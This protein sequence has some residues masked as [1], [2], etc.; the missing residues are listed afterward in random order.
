MHQLPQTR[1]AAPPQADREYAGMKARTSFH[2]ALAL[3]A[4]ALTLLAGP[5]AAQD[6]PALTAADVSQPEG[7]DD[8]LRM[9]EAVD[10][11]ADPD[12]LEF[13]LEAS[14]TELEIVPGK[15]TPAWTY[16]GTL[17]GPLIR[18][19]VGDRLIV[20][21]TN[22]LPEATTIHWHGVRVPNDMD[23]AP[24]LTQNPVEPGESFT[25]EFTLRDAGTYWYHP[26]FNS[27]AQV[28]RGLYGAIVVE[29][30]N[31]PDFGDELVIML[32]DMGLDDN[33]QFLPADRG[34]TFGV[35]FGREGDT[36]LLNGKLAPTLKVRTGK[37]QRWRVINAAITRYFPLAV[38]GHEWTRIGGDN[39]LAARS[40][41]LPR[42]VLIPGERADLIFTPEG[43][44][45][46]EVSMAWLPVDRGWG[47]AVGT[48]RVPF[49]NVQTVD[50]AAVQP[51]PVP[52]DLRTIAPVDISNAVEQTVE[53]SIMGG[54][55]STAMMGIN[56]E[57][58]N[59]MLE[60]EIGQTQ[61][62]TLVNNSDFDHPFHLHGFF[63]QVLDDSRVP[64]WKDTV[65]VPDHT[66]LRIAIDFDERRG[67][68]MF[69]CH[70]L[71]HAEAG[72]MASLLVR[73][74]N[75]PPG[76]AS[77]PAHMS[78]AEH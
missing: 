6:A 11:N 34:G 14:V 3:A 28:S 1:A 59:H 20:H 52:Q 16:N 31:E 60:A 53:L 62:W 51:L 8:D 49:L 65:N 21:F 70:I 27:P 12:V 19:K 56:G 5:A 26:H 77:A 45:G 55:D 17:P 46:D 43:E 2:G 39:G 63:F 36:I 57:A 54:D 40:E 9:E 24:R 37:Q 66:T 4:C 47:T 10:A 33:G 68:W 78:H 29:D 22:N 23:G 44:P 74:P 25:Y 67:M 69:H 76:E 41:K 7:W 50:E 72:M 48:S 35:L 42:M 71:D 32:S 18:A 13:N 61:V 30:P 64:E 75:A 15:M 73:D 58:H 38:R